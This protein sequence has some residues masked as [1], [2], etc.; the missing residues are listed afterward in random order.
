MRKVKVGYSGG[1]LFLRLSPELSKLEIV[2][3]DIVNVSLE[4]NKII[5]EREN[6][7]NE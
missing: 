1:S 3:G 7:T 2:H 4:G 5:I 6:K